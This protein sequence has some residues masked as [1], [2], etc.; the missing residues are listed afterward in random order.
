MSQPAN[1]IDRN[2]FDLYYEVTGP[3]SGSRSPILLNHG[4]AGTSRVWRAQA[5]A[6]SAQNEF[7]RWDLRGHGRSASPADEDAYSVDETV[8]DMAALLDHQGHERAIIGGHSL[9]GYMALA[10]YLK[11]PER[12]D[13]L[14]VVATGPGYKSDAPRDEWNIMARALGRRLE[15]HGLEELRKLDR[16]MDPADHDSVAGLGMAAR[17][18]LV[19]HDSRI[20]DSLA[21]IAVPTMIV[22]GEKDRGYLA[23]SHYMA[24]KIPDARLEIIPNAGHAVNLHQT[25]QF[26]A[27][28]T[29]YFAK[30]ASHRRSR[31]T[32][33]ERNETWT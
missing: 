3:E 4:F 9:G 1:H 18:L 12:V 31:S 27:A 6:F 17:G 22:I 20:I 2:G 11:Y 28:A 10:F 21:E 8:E 16:E 32:N 29:Q 23:A 25:E 19:Q 30:I 7:I 24:D 26:N 33:G 15:K 13:A 14:F 5:E